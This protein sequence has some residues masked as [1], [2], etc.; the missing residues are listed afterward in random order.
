M[1]RLALLAM[2]C[3]LSPAAARLTPLATPPDWSR[4]EAFQET[5]TREE[6]LRLLDEVYA[7]GGAWKEAIEIG[8]TS[9]TVRTRPG[10]PPF[11]LR[12]AATPEAARPIPRYW[13]PLA[14]LPPAPP[15]KPLA[16]LKIALDPGPVSY[17]HL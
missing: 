11:V 5:I 8:E 6:F 1:L 17:T 14:A 16:G 7:P 15:Q 10:H 12:F 2:L 3:S 4:L 13:R 9:A